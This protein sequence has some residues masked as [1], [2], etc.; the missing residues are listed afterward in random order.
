MKQ[1][2]RPVWEANRD[3]LYVC[4][5]FV[6]IPTSTDTFCSETMTEEAAVVFMMDRVWPPEFR[7][8]FAREPSL[9]RSVGSHLLAAMRNYRSCFKRYVFH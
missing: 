4:F 5:Y 8:L 1:F 9:V 6:L 3:K 2:Y 7:Q